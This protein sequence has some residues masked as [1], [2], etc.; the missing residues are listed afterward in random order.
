[1]WRGKLPKFPSQI[2]DEHQWTCEPCKRRKLLMN[3]R[4][5]ATCLVSGALGD[6]SGRHR[7][8]QFLGRLAER[9]WSLGCLGWVVFWKYPEILWRSYF[10][11]L[12]QKTRQWFGEVLC[13]VSFGECVQKLCIFTE[14]A[15]LLTTMLHEIQTLILL[16]QLL[17]QGSV[18]NLCVHVS[19]KFTVMF[20]DATSNDS[21]IWL[22]SVSRVFRIGET[23]QWTWPGTKHLYRWCQEFESSEQIC[24]DP[25]RTWMWK[26]TVWRSWPMA[27]ESLG[28]C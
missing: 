23:L 20:G 6:L 10:K 13:E 12:P 9:C 15:G 1:M 26:K 24:E 16:F 14:I 11:E 18:N 19:T 3:D 25:W 5:G 21:F 2:Q 28:F 27:N 22:T 8:C 7:K 4:R 17:N